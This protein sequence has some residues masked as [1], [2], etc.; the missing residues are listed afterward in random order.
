MIM[1]T[2][3]KARNMYMGQN[4]ATFWMIFHDFPGSV[5]TLATRIYANNA[6]HIK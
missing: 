2:G 3:L 1:Y 5:R 6:K 4:V